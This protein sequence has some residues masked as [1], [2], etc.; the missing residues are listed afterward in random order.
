MLYNYNEWARYADIENAIRWH[1]ICAH[2]MKQRFFRAWSP[3]K[4]SY[5]LK[6][7]RASELK[8]LELILKR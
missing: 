6:R 2:S 8:L 3:R 4:R 7:F 1:R 5:Y